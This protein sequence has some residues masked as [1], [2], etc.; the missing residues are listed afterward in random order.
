[1]LRILFH[2]LMIVITHGLWF[3]VLGVMFLVRRRREQT[4]VY[5]VNHNLRHRW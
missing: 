5:Q 3:I 2:L 1:M 4:V